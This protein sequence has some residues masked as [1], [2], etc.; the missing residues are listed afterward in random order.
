MPY[1]DDELRWSEGMRLRPRDYFR[2]GEASVIAPK[3]LALASADD[4]GLDLRGLG[5]TPDEVSAL[6]DTLGEIELEEAAVESWA[7]GV[8]S[9]DQL[10][11]EL[12]ELREEQR[13]MTDFE[14][15]KAY[16]GYG[17]IDLSGG[18]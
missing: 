13:N 14:F 6:A 1:D 10:E 15:A 7:D 4:L 5:A 11:A 16:E 3:I 8:P 18:T 2:L 9:I 17:E 12:A